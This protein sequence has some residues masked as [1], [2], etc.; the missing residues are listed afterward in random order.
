MRVDAIF[1]YYGHGNFG[2]DLFRSVLLDAL[3]QDE[4]ARPRTVL[5]GDDSSPLGALPR[6][7]ANAVLLARARTITLGGGSV[8]GAPR[9]RSLRAGQ[10]RAATRGT[11]FFGVGLG[12][13]DPP[14]PARDALLRRFDWLAL[15]SAEEVAEAAALRGDRPTRFMPDLAYAAGHAEGADPAPP[16]PVATI[17]PAEVGAIGHLAADP[18]RLTAWC[19]G[20]LIPF[21]GEEGLAPRILVLQRGH[22]GDRR[23]ADTLRAALAARDVEASVAIHGGVAET[24]G[25]LAR[26]AAVISDRLHGAIVAHAAGRPALLSRHHAKCDRFLAPLPAPATSM[27]RALAKL[28]DAAGFGTMGAL[29]GADAATRAAL[30]GRAQAA[31]GEWREAVVG[32]VR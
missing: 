3:G 14:G 1:G 4:I 2:D 27:G 20:A 13:K 26:S 16:D 10:M 24:R 30:A 15:R 17:V 12:L 5:R 19:D 6:R 28:A 7:I 32:A 31:L 22:E 9:P 18:V 11:P 25:H 21:L 29:D 8:L 23:V